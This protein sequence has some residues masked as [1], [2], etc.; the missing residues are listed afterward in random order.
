[1]ALAVI[2]TYQSGKTHDQLVAVPICYLLNA[3]ATRNEFRRAI[4]FDVYQRRA[5]Y[6]NDVMH[7]VASKL[8]ALSP[9]ALKRIAQEINA[10]T[11]RGNAGI[12]LKLTQEALADEA[13]AYIVSH[14]AVTDVVGCLV[15]LMQDL[16]QEVSDKVADIIDHVLPLNYAPGVI[17]RLYEHIAAD[18][19]GLVDNEV[20]TRTLAEII[21]AGYD[22][23]PAKFAAFADGSTDIRGQTALD[24]CDEPEE[25]PGHAESEGSRVLRAVCNLLYDLLALQDTLWGAPYHPL[26]RKTPSA[27]NEAELHRMIQDAAIR[28]RGA[29]TGVS[30]SNRGRTVYCVVQLPSEGTPQRDFRKRIIGEVHQHV[31][32][33]V[34]VELMQTPTDE[35]EFE[36][37]AYITAR[38]IRTQQM[39]KL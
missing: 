17:H 16:G 21:M 19:F 27:Q 26:H 25:G 9:E 36:V 23:K 34:F 8:N 18:Q 12:N 35:R 30:K 4:Q 15:G 6:R 7:A 32:L 1:M 38:V 29:L 28:L 11:N 24:Y 13:A 2:T 10:L 20:A 22:Q 31:P 14:T 33:L 3:E 5:E 37:G 39:R